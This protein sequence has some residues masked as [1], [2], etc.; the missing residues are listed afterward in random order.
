M[1]L[2]DRKPTGF[3]KF[4]LR[5]PIWFYRARLGRLLGQRYL[6]LAHRG[7]KSGV[8]R[9]TVV[10]VL[11]FS[12]AVP[13]VVVVAGWGAKADWYRNLVAAPALEVRVGA[14]SW[15]EPEHR[16]LCDAEALAAF[17]CYRLANPRSWKMLAPMLG[18]PSGPGDPRWEE[19]VCALPAIAFTPRSA[20]LDGQPDAQ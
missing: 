3:L 6:Y 2:V 12:R 8:R 13:E 14:T 15:L 7:R 19:A 20:Q 4:A 9:E 16:Y 11:S 18:L 1:G 10:E 17:E 5:A